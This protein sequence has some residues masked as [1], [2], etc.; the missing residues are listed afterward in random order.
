MLEVIGVACLV[1]GFWQALFTVLGGIW[2]AGIMAG[3]AYINFT[4]RPAS[5]GWGTLVLLALCLL[6][7]LYFRD[8]LLSVLAA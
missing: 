4:R 6:P 7:P 2:L 8:A 5:F 3:A 1:A